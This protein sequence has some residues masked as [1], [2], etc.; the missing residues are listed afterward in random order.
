M[1][2]QLIG[3]KKKAK[4]QQRKRQ[5]Y[6]LSFALCDIYSV[7]QTNERTEAKKRAMVKP[8]LPYVFPT[9]FYLKEQFLFHPSVVSKEHRENL[10][11][12]ITVFKD[13]NAT[14]EAM[15][16]MIPFTITFIR[17]DKDEKLNEYEPFIEA[18]VLGVNVSQQ[19]ETGAYYNI[20]K[21]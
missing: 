5:E 9:K 4:P 1:P 21:V 14:V 19:E 20:D 6:P 16:M 7:G 12:R 8:R 13:Q 3:I 2:P 17:F 18:N 10:M 15:K 11:K